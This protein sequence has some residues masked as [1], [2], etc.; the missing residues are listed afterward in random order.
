MSN[1]KYRKFAETPCTEH[2]IQAIKFDNGD[3]YLTYSTQEDAVR[4]LCSEDGYAY[5]IFFQNH[6]I[7]VLEKY[8]IA[9]VYDCSNI[10]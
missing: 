3:R 9:V 2:T 6:V 5:F 8:V 7:E 10:N 1:C 4:I